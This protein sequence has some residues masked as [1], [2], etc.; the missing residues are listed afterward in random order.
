MSAEIFVASKATM[1]VHDSGCE[2][3]DEIAEENAEEF[4]SL[5]EALGNGYEAAKCCL[6]FTSRNRDRMERR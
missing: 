2:W 1:K 3:A 6:Q 5:E 4:T